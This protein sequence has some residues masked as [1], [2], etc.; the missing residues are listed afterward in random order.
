MAVG[1]LLLSHGVGAIYWVGS[2]Q[3]ARGRGL[4]LAISRTLTNVAFRRGAGAR[5]LQ[6]TAMAQQMY[7]QIGHE[8]LFHY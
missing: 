4:G 7:G 6:S 8:E 1:H 5:T 3:G 2:M